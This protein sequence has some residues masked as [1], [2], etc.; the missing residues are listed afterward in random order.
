MQKSLLII[1]SLDFQYPSLTIVKIIKI[2]TL[3]LLLRLSPYLQD[4][5][6]PISLLVI[7]EN[8]SFFRIDILVMDY[9]YMY[10]EGILI[11]DLFKD[12]LK[13]SQ[14]LKKFYLINLI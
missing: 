9:F 10:Y 12:Y 13:K 1:L 8:L 11:K 4:L 5:Q 6:I 3:Y 7:C 14:Y 2:M